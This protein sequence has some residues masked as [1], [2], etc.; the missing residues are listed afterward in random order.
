MN[1]LSCLKAGVYKANT[2]AIVTICAL[3]I[4]AFA[5]LNIRKEG[6]DFGQITNVA[7]DSGYTD[8]WLV[9]LSN[10]H[11]EREYIVQNDA[12]LMLA[13]SAKAAE[14]RVRIDY[15]ELPLASKTHARYIRV[16][17]ELK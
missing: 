2:I 4:G 12:R 16:L 9:T 8:N 10:D 5:L 11:G 14:S 6:S 15:V 3:L 17:K 13:I 7:H 1:I